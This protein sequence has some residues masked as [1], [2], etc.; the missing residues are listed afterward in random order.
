MALYL[1]EKFNLEIDREKARQ[2]NECDGSRK[3]F[4]EES[5]SCHEEDAMP[6]SYRS[7]RGQIDDELNDM[8]EKVLVVVRRD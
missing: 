3:R 5:R 7:W 4:E 2:P 1:R 6:G 8:E